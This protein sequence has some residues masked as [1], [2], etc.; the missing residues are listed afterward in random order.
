MSI[1]AEFERAFQLHQQGKL[2]E[3]FLRY[4]SILKAAPQHAGA[5]HFSGLALH[6]AGKHAE[7]IERIR[8]SLRIDPQSADAIAEHCADVANQDAG[9]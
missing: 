6:Q 3:A 4:D 9:R 5:L 8:A 1:D 7:A 2:R